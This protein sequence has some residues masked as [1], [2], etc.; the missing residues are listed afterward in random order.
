MI[1]NP[2][3]GEKESETTKWDINHHDEFPKTENNSIELSM[4]HKYVCG[5]VELLSY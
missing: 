5:L 4:F 3:K 1:L 2:N